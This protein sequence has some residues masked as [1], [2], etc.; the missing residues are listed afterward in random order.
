MAL[1][2]ATAIAMQ[3][4]LPD[5]HLLSPTFLFPAAE[6]LLLVVLLTRHGV[7]HIDPWSIA[8]RRIILGLVVVM[9]IDS[10]LAV[11]ELVRDILDGSQGDN[12]TVLLATG[13]AVWLTNII[14]FS[15][16]F[17]MLDR[18]GPTARATGHAS[19]PSFV[20]ATMENSA[21]A[22]ADWQPKYFDYLYLA[23]TNATAFSPTDTM[24]VT[25][26][27]KTLMLVQSTISLVVAL[28]IIARAVSML[29]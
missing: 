20:F 26:W 29:K 28:M 23:F 16:W 9:S 1:A 21:F 6:S 24:P 12:G 18:G 25:R 11:V 7:S 14:A 2:V 5:R 27:A 13:G 15:V 3:F 19:P 4:A 8:R 22:P 10:L 17:W